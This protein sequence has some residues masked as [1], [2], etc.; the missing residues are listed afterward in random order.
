MSERVD[1]YQPIYCH[2]CNRTY[3][4]WRWAVKSDRIAQCPEC[5]TVAI[6]REAE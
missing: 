3:P 5:R 6:L 4:L 1:V 2:R